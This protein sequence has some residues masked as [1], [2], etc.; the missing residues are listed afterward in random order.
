[1]NTEEAILSVLTQA[2]TALPLS[3]LAT[4][5]PDATTRTLQRR[6]AQLVADGR[7]V[8]EG[9][10]PATVY[11]TVAVVVD[12]AGSPRAEASSEER[13][14]NR[15]GTPDSG[16]VLFSGVPLGPEAREVLR[17]VLRPLAA[18]TPVGW[19]RDWLDMYVPNQTF[20]L[21]ESARQRLATLGDTGMGELPAGTYGRGIMERLLID[22]SWAS[23]HLEGNTYT[24]LDTQELIAHGREATGRAATETQMILNHKAAIELLLDQA[25][26]APLSISVVQGLHA[27]LSENLLQDAN[28]EGR[29]RQRAVWISGSCYRPLTIPAQIREAMEQ[30]L[31][32]ATIIADPFERSF[33]LL[34]HIAYLQPFVDVNKRTARMLCNLPF[35][36]HNLCPLTFVDVNPDAWVLALL[37]VYEQTRPE[38]LAD[39]YVWAYERSSNEYLAVR[40]TVAALNPLRLQF[41]SALHDYV[42]TVIR[43]PDADPLTLLDA[44][45][46]A[47]IPAA[48]RSAMRDLAMDE[49]RRLHE[50]TLA[51]YG[52]RHSEWE[53]WLRA[54]G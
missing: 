47:E 31:R 53:R 35:L 12:E 32:T 38:L 37:G 48:L 50:G 9:R 28:D 4:R 30:V 21:S 29:L 20:L 17:S 19:Q 54:Q 36:E 14:L 41:R 2:T 7:V 26:Q 27:A 11:S 44:W 13:P 42:R 22:L 25:G 10:G 1:M 34:V 51:R 23:S 33:F 49:L 24:R 45:L 5:V 52:L 16:R 15:Y 8:R 39:L 40:Q 3:D 18:R 46:T 43:S 6:L